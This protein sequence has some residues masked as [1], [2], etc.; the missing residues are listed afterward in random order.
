[1]SFTTNKPTIEGVPQAAVAGL[2]G[3]VDDGASAIKV[4]VVR[5]VWMRPALAI[6]V[7]V[8]MLV[9][10]VAYALLQKPQYAAS[11]QLY[12]VPTGAKLLATGT[13]GN[14]DEG[15]YETF[16]SEQMLLVT[17]PDVLKAALG[18]LPQDNWAEFGA[19]EPAAAANLTTVL[20]VA[21]VGTSHQISIG[22]KGS[23][24]VK[25]AAVVNAITT[26]YIEA[27]RKATAADS[28]QRAQLLA[29]ERQLIEG[30]LQ[31]DRAEQIALGASMGVANPTVEG[32]NP[33]DAALSTL[34]VQLSEA[35]AAHEVAAAQLASLS[36]V[37]PA[38]TLGL[39]A[40]ADEQ[41]LGDAGLGSMKA[42]I[43]QRKAAV[44]AQMAGMTP[45]NPVYKQDQ[46]ELADLDRT[47]DKM[48]V[49]LRDKAA[50]RLQDKLHTD[51]QRTGDVE[52][53]LNGQL[54]RQIASATSAAPRL[55]RATEVQ[56]DIQRLGVQ[57]ATVDEA[58]R[59]LR[60]EVSGP[61]QVR[62]S[63]PA[64]PADSPEA[65]KRKQ[66]L[67]L[68][69]PLAI[70]FGIGAAVL[71][72]LRDKRIYLGLDVA[73]V[74]GFPPLAVLPARGAVSQRVFEEYVL[75]LAAGIE[76]AYRTSGARTFLL[77][78]VSAST[79][80]R[81]LASAL[82]RKFEEIGVNVVV[83][84]A[85]EMLTPMDSGSVELARPSESGSAGFVAANVAKMKT[86]HGLVLIE[87]EALLHCA[88][89][90]YL[91]RCADATILVIECSVTTRE[92][93]SGATDLLH[94]LNVTRIAAVLEEV[95]L[96]HTDLAFR[97]SI[98]ALDRRQVD[99]RPQGAVGRIA[100]VAVPIAPLVA[101]PVE[102]V[103][104][105]PIE[106]AVALPP[107]LVEEIAAPVVAPAEVPVAVPATTLMGKLLEAE[108]DRVQM[109]YEPFH[110][111]EVLH[112]VRET[113]P[114]EHNWGW[115]LP[116]FGKTATEPAGEQAVEPLRTKASGEDKGPFEA[117]G[118]P[119]SPNFA[120]TVDTRSHFG[121]DAVENI[122]SAASIDA[123]SCSLHEKIARNLSERRSAPVSDGDA[124]MT[125]KS[126]WFDKLLR[127]ESDAAGSI[128]P[129]DDDD[130][131]ADVQV[132]APVLLPAAR[133]VDLNQAVARTGTGAE[134]YDIPL[135]ARLDH[136]SRQR[137]AGSGSHFGLGT[138]G[139]RP[140]PRLQIVPPEPV[141]AEPD[142]EFPADKEPVAAV[143][144][145]EP[146]PES[147]EVAT[148]VAAPEVASPEVMP[149]HESAAME[150]PLVAAEP[151]VMPDAPEVEAVPM[152]R[153]PP[154]RPLSF[155]ELAGMW[156][157]HEPVSVAVAQVVTPLPQV[158]APE[159]L[160]E[161]PVAQSGPFDAHFE[162]EFH[163][164]LESASLDQGLPEFAAPVVEA[165]L[166]V[167]V[168]AEPV[169][170]NPFEA[171]DIEPV[172]Q[173]ASRNL[174]NSRWD[175]IPT[176]RPSGIWRD[177]PSPVPVNGNGV[178]RQY[179]KGAV[180]DGFNSNPPRR[181]IPEEEPLPVEEA[182]LLPEP[183]L[184][185]QWGLL[186]R[187]QQ[188]R[189]VSN[190]DDRHGQ[191]DPEHTH[192]SRR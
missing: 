120:H 49:D 104:A 157:Q 20:K 164:P 149:S 69:L 19:T 38:G 43:S 116:V 187:F 70:L 11:S 59:N 78:A 87:A 128:V 148:E 86:E 171:D 108:G 106:A 30:E 57:L 129:T 16:L 67:M 92:E 15:Q 45:T 82:T 40:A 8:V 58:L 65:N 56:A 31:A 79:D 117:A 181:W 169:R 91:A 186:S 115:H 12:E 126:S 190:S 161:A 102:P 73:H 39:M 100:E 118:Q 26:V 10:V 188:A 88:Q 76:S 160:F 176:L 136:I 130:D 80:I 13:S 156:A 72:R 125:R 179:S 112:H 142:E 144:E 85:S 94:R 146:A 7:A 95:D 132:P 63:I 172:Y 158:E 127:R 109:E 168:V 178:G 119:S 93:L 41:I 137:S 99:S 18:S 3:R 29:E 113:R 6:G 123:G 135:V 162:P 98:D 175:P 96:R 141:E 60:L 14:V 5:S 37:G 110:Y 131:V 22:L 52:A 47:L 34:R 134:E 150:E 71:A 182:E 153:V 9:L 122:V 64:T 139:N 184:S 177:R 107:E 66:L 114:F 32:G 89:T 167:D 81:P 1:M 159:T 97:K 44:T 191:E 17:R 51:L 121:L 154:R 155:H 111:N 4:Q 42:S 185:R 138:G 147:V 23:D 77:T 140:V 152:V 25:T 165:A 36:G 166:V 61:A 83:A 174:N 28:D 133:T 46:D 101:V 62:L 192:D 54:A 24:P 33:Y 21:R 27:A 53:R 74:L 35:R 124:S 2:P 84:T 75:R 55:Q 105:A 189:Q 143:V 68:A 90:E 163:V 170:T 151:E 145:A 180:Q 50:R 48:T 103:V 173:E 183:M